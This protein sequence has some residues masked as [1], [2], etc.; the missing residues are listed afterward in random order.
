VD[1]YV[2]LSEDQSHLRLALE[3][4]DLGLLHLVVQIVTLTSTLSDTS[5]DGITTVGL[6][7]V[8][9]QLLNE[10]SLADTGTSEQT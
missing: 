7:D 10:D 8:V 9:D 1:T 4:D 2:H 6:G 5:E 3:L